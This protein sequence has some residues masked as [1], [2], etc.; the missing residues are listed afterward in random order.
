MEIILLL[1]R[2]GTANYRRGGK[3]CHGRGETKH[4]AAAET[5]RAKKNAKITGNWR[6]TRFEIIFLGEV[7]Q[8]D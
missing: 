6:S 2:M 8:G 3:Q 4:S 7:S 5:E 1:G